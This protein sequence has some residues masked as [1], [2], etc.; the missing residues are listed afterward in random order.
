M[1]AE[2]AAS[3]AFRSRGLVGSL[4]VL[5]FG[6]LVLFSPPATIDARWGKVMIEA[7]GWAVFVAGAALRFWATLYIG[8][9]KRLVLVCEGPYSLCRNPLYVG[10]FLIALSAAVMLASVTFA[11]GIVIGAIFYAWATVPA[12]ERYLAGQL[13]E[14]YLRYCRQVPRFCPRFSGFTTAATINVSVRSLWNECRRAARWIWLPV[15]VEAVSRLRGEAW[16]PRW[17]NLP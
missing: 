11:A 1:E 8:G 9:R 10:T 3:W 14:P 7:L 17:L 6:G 16:W 2:Q 15:V 12:E 13:G 5:A 4:L